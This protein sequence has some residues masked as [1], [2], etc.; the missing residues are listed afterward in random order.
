MQIPKLSLRTTSIF[1]LISLAH[2]ASL[3]NLNF[4]K[5]K[6]E[7]KI[8]DTAQLISQE[9]DNEAFALN[10]RNVEKSI[11]PS[12]KEDNKTGEE[13]TLLN[14]LKILVKVQVLLDLKRKL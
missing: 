5:P 11:L 2:V 9:N 10:L 14:Y 8:V 4:Y 3:I 1:I 7:S 12:V 6:P 13:I